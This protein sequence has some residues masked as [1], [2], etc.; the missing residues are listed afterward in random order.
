MS[1]SARKQQVSQERRKSA[2][3][4]SSE[5][6]AV[7][8]VDLASLDQLPNRPLLAFC[9]QDVR[10]L[11][12]VLGT[13]DFRLC[14]AISQTILSGVFTGAYRETLL[15]P[16][17]GRIGLRG[18]FVIGLG[19]Y[20][21]QEPQLQRHEIIEYGLEAV[22][23]AKADPCLCAIP[24]AFPSSDQRAEQQNKRW[25]TLLQQLGTKVVEGIL[26]HQ[27]VHVALPTVPIF[28]SNG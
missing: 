21:A 24:Q 5:A 1:I 7:L 9:Y 26:L 22:L 6:I 27:P 10:P 2:S 12:G 16:V 3:N 20:N 28:A 15:L 23:K 17:R 14:G 19:P 4:S 25:L 18:L 11:Q 13:L 8:P